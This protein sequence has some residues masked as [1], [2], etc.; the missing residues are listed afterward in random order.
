MT[1]YLSENE[2]KIYKMAT[3]VLLKLLTLEWDI[4][5][6]I[7]G[8]EVSDGS[9]FFFFH[10]SCSFILSLTFFLPEFPFNASHFRVSIKDFRLVRQLKTK[11]KQK[12][13]KLKL[14]TLTRKWLCHRLHPM[15]K[16]TSGSWLDQH[17]NII[18]YLGDSSRI[19]QGYFQDVSRRSHTLLRRITGTI[20]ISV[21]VRIV[22]VLYTC[23]KEGYKQNVELN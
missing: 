2:A 20:M 10:F 23:F 11:T 6:I 18:E 8:I 22:L 3:S 15:S 16:I 14:F 5:R 9:Y 1:S 4:L 17:S 12:A 13:A 19:F 21:Y 7:W